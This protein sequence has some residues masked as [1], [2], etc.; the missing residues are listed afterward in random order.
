MS[1]IVT[2]KEEGGEAVGKGEARPGSTMDIENVPASTNAS[3]AT[4]VS[5]PSD[6]SAA[7]TGTF[8]FVPLEEEIPT[9]LK[10]REMKQSALKWGVDTH[11]VFQRYRFDEKF[12]VEKAPTFLCDFFNDANVQATLKR[13]SRAGLS[14]GLSGRTSNVDHVVLNTSVLT[15]TSSIV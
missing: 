1:A 10:E 11:C 6:K 3:G 5:A 7:D 9:I 15:M 4:L 8:K 13:S 14:R 2:E 12:S